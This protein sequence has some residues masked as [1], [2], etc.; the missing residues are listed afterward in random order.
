M[1]LVRG[2]SAA[3]L[4][5]GALFPLIAAAQDTIVLPAID[6]SVSRLGFGITGSST[7]I[8]SAEDIAQSP[9]QN[10]P[11][12]L[13]QQTG[14]QILHVIG[15]PTGTGDLVDLRGFGAFAQ[16]NVLVLVNG[17]RIQDFDLQGFD[18][19]SIPLNT[20]ERV[21]VTRG[22]SGSVL[23][24]D[25]AIGGVINI[26]TKSAA[27]L[28]TPARLEGLIGSY[29]YEEGRLSAGK[30]WGPWSVSTFGNV[31][32]S[33]GYR[34]N[35][36]LV[37]QNLIANLKY[38]GDSWTGYVNVGTDSQRQGLPGALPNLPLIYPITF[39]DPRATVTPFDWGDKKDLNITAGVAHMLAPGVDLILDGGV[40]RKF[41]RSEF[42][43]Y[44]NTPTF[45]FDTLSAV[46]SNYVN[47]QMTTS[48]LTPRLDAT[49]QLFG[50]H[51]RLLTGIDLYNTD[52][53][54]DRY[55][56]PSVKAPIHRYDISQATAAIYG[57]NTTSVL[58]DLDISIGG[59][60]QRNWVEATD[61][62]HASVDPNAGFYTVSPQAPALDTSEWQYAAHAG[63]AYRV[64]PVL[65]FFARGARAFRLPNADERV[66][67][68][69]PFGTFPVTLDLKTQ[70]SYDVEGGFRLHG[71]RFD[72]ESSV[73]Q[74][75]L[76]N[77]IHF[78]PALFMDVNL[79]PTERRGWETSAGLRPA[80]NLRLRGGLAYTRA[81][82][83][84]GPF[85]GKD[86]PLVSRW[87]GNAGFTW[88]IVQK[89]LVLDVDA[90]FWSDR[91][92]D[93]DQANVQ[94]VIP[95][96]ATV[97]I[98]IGGVYERLSWSVAV[99]NLL[100]VDYFDYA[101]ASANF[102]GYYNAYPQPGRAFL[103][104]L[105]VNSP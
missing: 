81:V 63:I 35:S 71:D 64:T 98:K 68:G 53:A 9:A 84:E 100:D 26:V 23:Y 86:V 90:R 95:A 15:G 22:N 62:Y 39:A 12:I 50:V 82:F 46:P 2:L 36:T 78:I 105:A 21:E 76:K 55:Q 104:R 57:M 96:N 73:Y 60:L 32:A 41:Q 16:S 56:S 77:E 7:S 87:S 80:D 43:N 69:N 45:T 13:G 5:L 72:F 38:K 1:G 10:L 97:D 31:V 70:T 54:S 103:V 89:L 42:F 92:M 75:E 20:I 29:G 40:R 79:D 48:S 27:S 99:Q 47:T 17:R 37:E 34:R 30:A 24:G 8:I 44:F 6:V 102:P 66:G 67:A 49:H 14:V 19:S 101:L 93:N 85:A 83:R 25:G 59:R 88:N 65:T 91:R 52:Y 28:P 74:M 61:T 18:F 51:N 33:S 3:V 58:P 94:P 11:D 4:V